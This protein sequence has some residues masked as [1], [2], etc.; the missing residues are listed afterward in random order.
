MSDTPETDQ[1]EKYDGFK[2]KDTVTTCGDE[3]SSVYINVIHARQLERERNETRE[4]A[5]RYRLEANAMMLQRDEARESLKHIGEYG[6]EEIN[7]AI[8]LRQK[9]ASALVERDEAR[10]ELSLKQQ[11]LTIAEGTLFDLRKQRDVARDKYDTLATEHMLVVNKLCEERDDAR[12]ALSRI[13]E[14]FCDGEDTHDDWMKMGNI[15][16]DYFKGLE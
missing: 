10:R 13:D 2:I 15:A 8:D 14:I 11:T 12:D 16:K 5:E 6:T 7:A 4:K 3:S 1:I 9:L